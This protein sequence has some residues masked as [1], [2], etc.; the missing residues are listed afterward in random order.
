MWP[1][2]RSLRRDE[3]DDDTTSGFSTFFYGC[4]LNKSFGL[5]LD[6]ARRKARHE[7]RKDLLVLGDA[8][9]SGAVGDERDVDT[10][11]K[12]RER[13]TDARAKE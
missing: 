12:L 10:A 4:F 13:G 6:N 5:L 1:L 2:Y 8:P 9:G 11:F 3:D 7:R